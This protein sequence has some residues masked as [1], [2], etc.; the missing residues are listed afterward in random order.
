MQRPSWVEQEPEPSHIILT[1][2]EG[3]P[4]RGLHALFEAKVM[5]ALERAPK[6]R[7]E[8]SKFRRIIML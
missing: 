8:P 6:R 7:A 1:V 2:Y 4:A 5:L 3:R